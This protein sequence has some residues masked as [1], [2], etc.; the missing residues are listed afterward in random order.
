MGRILRYGANKLYTIC[1]LL[2]GVKIGK[3]SMIHCRSELRGKRKI[4][5]GN[6]SI[7]YKNL[8]IYIS[9]KGS[10]S[11]GSESHIAPY[12]YFLVENQNITI[13]DDV[14]IGVYSSFFCSSVTP[15]Y[16]KTPYHEVLE[17]GDIKIGNNVVIAAH[18]TILPGTEIEDNVFVAANA[19]VKGKLESGWLYAGSPCKP[20]KKLSEDD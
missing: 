19:V 3:G 7:L 17:H 11:I 2:S 16:G 12:A 1:N 18:C 15:V 4:S 9:K 6:N 13:G 20:V 5:L 14:A 10:F 8:T